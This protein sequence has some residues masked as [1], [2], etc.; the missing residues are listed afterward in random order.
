MDPDKVVTHRSPYS[1]STERLVAQ[2]GKYRNGQTAI[3]LYSVED[4]L[5]YCT[6]TVAVEGANIAH[7]EVVIKNYSENSGILESM[8]AA[9]IIAKPHSEIKINFVTAQVCKLL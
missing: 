6:A 7:D 2:F 3:R 9:G 4:G 1:H 8:I 5:P